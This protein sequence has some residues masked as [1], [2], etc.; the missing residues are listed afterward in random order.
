MRYKHKYKY[1]LSKYTFS[2]CDREKVSPRDS[3]RT[4]ILSGIFPGAVVVRGADWRWENQ[5]GIL[6]Y[7]LYT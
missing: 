4:G 1:I 3:T 7:P 2:L 5:D 6:P